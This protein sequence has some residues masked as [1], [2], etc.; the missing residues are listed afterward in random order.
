MLFPADQRS[1]QGSLPI[2]ARWPRYLMIGS[3][4]RRF[5]MLIDSNVLARAAITTTD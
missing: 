1:L 3:G 2:R 4:E 5:E